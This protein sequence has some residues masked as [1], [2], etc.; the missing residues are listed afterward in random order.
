MSDAPKTDAKCRDY[1]GPL[2]TIGDEQFI[3]AS[4]ARDLERDNAKLRAACLL[5]I[6]ARKHAGY[7]MEDAEKAIRAAL[8]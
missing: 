1:A 7:G 4:F 3:P 8:T 5:F 6:E 2:C